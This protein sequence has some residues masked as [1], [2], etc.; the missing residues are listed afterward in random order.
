ML[1]VLTTEIP[2]PGFWSGTPA[3][4]TGGFEYELARDLGQRFGLKFVHVKLE[5]FNRIVSGQLD[6]ADLALDLITPTE[7]RSKVLEFSTPY[8]Q[9]PP[10]IVVRSRTAV[11][12][13][14]TA[15]TLRWGAVGGTTFVE[16]VKALITPDTP[17]RTFDSNAEMLN[18]L[19]QGEVDAIVQDM[20]L[21]VATA[22]RSDGRLLA[23]A[24]LP[25]AETIAA[26]LPR[27]SNNVEAVDSAIRAFM[28]D[29][30]I[31]RLLQ[32][33]IGPSA[34]DAEKAIPLLRTSR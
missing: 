24:Q 33:W 12:D 8:L 17:L 13:L 16:I 10:T 27:G 5:P 9:S 6:G 3:H 30:T 29:G 21:A 25:S 22:D 1:T 19:K 31:D 18:A 28:S 20:P 2:S 11:S 7:R 34:A 14:A 23:A 4:V 26:A 32:K 15:R